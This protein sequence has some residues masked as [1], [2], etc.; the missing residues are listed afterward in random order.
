MSTTEDPNQPRPHRLAATVG[1]A[2]V[3]AMVAALVVYAVARLTSADLVVAPPGQPSGTVNAVSV[4]MITLVGGLSALLVALVLR[5]LA[6]TRGR[7]LF[8]VLALIV[9]AVS[10]FGPLGAS[11]QTST[12]VWL[13]IMH[14]VFA[15]VI[16]TA[17]LRA[18]PA[19]ASRQAAQR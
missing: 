15:A 11:T 10:F 19:P 14:V 17:T 7:V 5:R 6:P 8:L 4:I 12:A 9:L 16:I 1:V 2:T 18:L 3:I 13:G